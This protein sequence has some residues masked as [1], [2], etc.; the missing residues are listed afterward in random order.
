MNQPNAT[1]SSNNLPPPQVFCRFCG[2]PMTASA[3]IC[4]HCNKSQVPIQHSN[5]ASAPQQK[6]SPKRKQGTTALLAIF[7]GGFGVHRFYLGQWWGFIYLLFC[8]TLIPSVIGILEGILF[9]LKQKR[10]WKKKYENRE[11]WPAYVI[12]LIVAITPFPLIAFI[13]IAAAVL[14]PL[15]VETEGR[16]FVSQSISE[17]SELKDE[18]EFYFIR[19]KR[20]PYPDSNEVDLG[21]YSKSNLGN[22]IDLWYDGQI[23]LTL[24]SEKKYLSR[25]TIIFIP[26]VDSNDNF[27]WECRDGTLEAQFRP[28]EC[29]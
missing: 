14:L 27:S 26:T 21:L 24:H 3:S 20:F 18:L 11:G 6:P 25:K 1:D 8:W 16:D 15:Y 9:S 28:Q 23:R 4:P 17:T 19:H 2:K 29:R 12:I 7:L 10:A 13:G 5:N 22:K